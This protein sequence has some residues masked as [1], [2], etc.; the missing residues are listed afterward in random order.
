MCWEDHERDCD[1][2][3]ASSSDSEDGAQATSRDAEYP[4]EWRN[5]DG[6]TIYSFQASNIEPSDVEESLLE[7]V[8]GHRVVIRGTQREDLNGRRGTIA[9]YHE[10]TDRF[11][12][13]IDETAPFEHAGL[14]S[15]VGCS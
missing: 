7:H 4:L 3:E 1:C 14:Q 2:Q 9:S 13:A 12:V 11:Y 8:R 15:S 5:A 10:P 6:R